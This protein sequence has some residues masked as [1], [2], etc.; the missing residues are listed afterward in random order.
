MIDTTT[1]EPLSV[2]ID[3]NAPPYIMVPET[4]LS[5]VQALGRP[6][7]QRSIG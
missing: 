3:G 4:L 7:V 6:D 1:Q 2:S 5:T